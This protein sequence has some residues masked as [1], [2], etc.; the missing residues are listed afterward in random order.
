LTTATTATALG[1]IMIMLST[2]DQIDAMLLEI[3]F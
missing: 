2:L 3:M 1:R